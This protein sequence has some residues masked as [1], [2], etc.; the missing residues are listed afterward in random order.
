MPSKLSSA[1]PA[2]DANTPPAIDAP[3]AE[4]NSY[5]QILESS[6][7]IGSSTL[8]TVILGIIR[9][10]FVAELLGPAGFGLM[11]IYSSIADLAKTLSTMGVNSSGVR[12]IANA[13]GSNDQARIALTSKV[14]RRISI[15]LGLAGAA[16]IVL[17]AEKISIFT[18]SDADNTSYVAQISFVV[19]FSCIAG[20][21]G[22]LIQGMR[23]IGDLAK[24]SIFG[25]LFGTTISIV[26]VYIY[27]EDGIVPS[28][29]GVAAM[30]FLTSWW[31]SK[32]INLDQTSITFSQACTETS[33]LL[34]LGFA[35]M[36]SSILMLGSAYAVRVYLLRTIG[37]ESVGL[38]QAA[39]TVGGLYVSF[40]FTAMGTDFYP[41]LAGAASN[42]I[43]CNK[44]V[45][46]QTH[47]SLLLAG[48]GVVASL[49][50][51]PLLIGVFY[52]REFLEADLI[53]RWIC[54]GMALRVITWP[55]GFIILAKSESKI[56]VCVEAAWTA[57]YIGLTVLCV[58][59][60]GLSGAGIAFFFSYVFHGFLI[61]PITNRL[62]GF[63][64]SRE[65]LRTGLLFLFSILLVFI[66][67][68]ILPVVMAYGLGVL[69]II[70]NSVYSIRALIGLLSTDRLPQR[71][72]KLVARMH[73]SF[74]NSKPG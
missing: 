22:A 29:I 70:L 13:V 16:L 43:E 45:N 21:Q 5:H 64:W 36:A 48:P 46:Q 9:T 25:A 62:V 11:G 26:L 32:K 51:A 56:F 74:S 55:M 7:L 15:L 72:Q 54:L 68:Q 24:M 65:N 53:L 57:V 10:K 19:I 39:W 58:S 49:T 34:R 28:L 41:R 40:I 23:R 42:N 67:F 50:F 44:L 52:S 71:V 33:S 38:Y 30:S 4:K 27:G 37:L 35:F 47:V 17:C 61:Y 6:A 66:G 3:S 8:V 63:K 73:F 14:L 18:F 59:I 69:I 12:Q 60:F 20:G 31:Y 1:T 2:D